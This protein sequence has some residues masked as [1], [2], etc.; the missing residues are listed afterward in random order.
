[1][2]NRICSD[3]FTEDDFIDNRAGGGIRVLKKAAYHP[4]GKRKRG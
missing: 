3:H 4:L 2:S 1:M